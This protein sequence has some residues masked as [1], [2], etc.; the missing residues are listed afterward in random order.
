MEGKKE[1]NE[2]E[3]NK[4]KKKEITNDFYFQRCVIPLGF[5]EKKRGKSRRSTIL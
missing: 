4:T 2:G 5:S 1:E 3:K